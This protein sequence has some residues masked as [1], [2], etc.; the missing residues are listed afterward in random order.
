MGVFDSDSGF[1]GT[2]RL[3]FARW[4][5]QLMMNS[6]LR[7]SPIVCVAALA[8]GSISDA[9]SWTKV[10]AG[11]PQSAGEPLLLLDGT[12][13][14][15]DIMSPNWYRL[16]PDNKGN[17]A[18]GTWKKTATMSSDYGPLYFT[19]AVLKDG[20]MVVMGGE[21]NLGPSVWTNK[22][23]IYDPILDK[24]TTLS[25]PSGWNNIGDAQCTV[26]PDGTLVMAMPFDTR[27][28]G[29]DASTLTWTA[30]SSA[31]K[32]DRHDEEG[33][34]LLPD[35]T[36]LAPCAENAPNTERYLPTL[37]KWILSGATPQ[38]LADAGSEE[39][40]PLVLLPSGK[41]V[42]IG[43]IGHNAL[44]TPG[45]NLQ[46]PGTWTA[47]PDLPNVGGQLALADA[48]AVLLPNGHVLFGASPGVFA[49]PT[50]YY[51]FDG[52]GAFTAT[53][54]PQH[55][56]NHSC[57]TGN[58]LMLP[59]GQALYTDFSDTIELYSGAGTYQNSWRP[60][61]TQFPS[62]LTLGKTAVI[63]GKQFNGLSQ[64]SSYG[65]DSTN[66]TNY[67]LAR[68]K[69][70]NGSKNT[71]YF[72]TFGHSSMGVATGN[73]VVQTNIAIPA[74][75]ETGAATLEI[76][77][78]GIP[79]VPVDVTITKDALKPDSVSMFEGISSTGTV[80]N[81]LASDNSY[82][83]V[84]SLNM[85]ASGQIAS[86]FA[87]FTI[88]GG[89]ANS[90]QFSFETSTS[91]SPVQ[92]LYFVYNFTTNK[93]DSFGSASQTTADKTTTFTVT[94]AAKYVGPGGSVKILIRAVN[95]SRFNRAASPVSL[96]IDK[97]DLSPG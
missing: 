56:G 63:K 5:Q 44:Y 39:I 40:G 65:D 25:A 75:A 83:I 77:A 11:G 42:A 53:V 23:A 89:S 95:P 91:Q 59:T 12:V 96:K 78:N 49:S 18:N 54:A 67:P 15:H 35:G 3:H 90:L 58:F 93:Y 48:P 45:A 52:T 76:V 27:M 88:P 9:Q 1:K 7:W 80:A 29:L 38:S 47:L 85:G 69:Y 13:M 33:W 79:S 51:E 46:D 21:Y 8:L 30:M 87:T 97:V 2:F 50:Y 57:Y 55:G 34:T 37:G 36:I 4:E 16:S 22:G 41:V 26:L 70:K 74:N 19:S 10:P 6:K 14:V 62:V 66:A 17:Y 43:A 81:I 20:R 84:N 94:N 64:C 73:L 32:S 31:G 72:R 92:A 71:V 82:F 28:A 86:A 68:I 24:W 60:A 61:I